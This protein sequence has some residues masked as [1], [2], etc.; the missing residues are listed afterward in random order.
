[1]ANPGRPTTRWAWDSLSEGEKTLFRR[2]AEVHAGFLSHTDHE[3]GRLLDY[4]ELTDEL[5]DTIVVS[6]EPYVDLE[7]ETAG[8]FMRD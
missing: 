2:V 8:A 4:L 7:K 6:G 1:M 5:D 3:I